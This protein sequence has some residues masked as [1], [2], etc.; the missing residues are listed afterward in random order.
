MFEAQSIAFILKK[1]IGLTLSP[2]PLTLLCIL[3]ALWWLPKARV[4]SALAMVMAFCILGLSAWNP[5]ADRLIRYHEQGL[6]VFDLSQPVDVVVVLGGPSKSTPDESSALMALGGSPVYRLMEGVRILR[7]NPHA[8]LIVTGYS[9]L[10]AT[11]PHAELLQAAAIEQGVAPERITAFPEARDTEHEAQLTAPLLR[12]KRFALVTEGAHMKRAMIF[13]EQEQ[14]NPIPA[15]AVFIG[16]RYT[17][18]RLDARGVS[19]TERAVY[20]TL[21]RAWQTLKHAI[22]QVLSGSNAETE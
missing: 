17:D 16:A 19:K 2:I 21:G 1:L 3:L 11:R 4:K 15:P 12:G 18:W 13:F 8:Q 6:A 10:S 7:A 9:G 5:I 22:T 14:L 20:E